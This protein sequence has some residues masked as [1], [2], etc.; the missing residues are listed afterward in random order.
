M[1]VDCILT[2]T[3]ENTL[4]SDFIPMFIRMWRTLVPTADIKIIY[5]ADEIP[6]K[7]KNYEDNLILFKPIDGINTAFIAQYIRILYPSL[8]NYEGG[9]IITDMDMMPMNS[10][11]YV[12]NIK[13]F[14]NDKFIYYRDWY[15]P[16]QIAICYNIATPKVWKEINGVNSIED[17]IEKL[18]TANNQITYAGTHGG[19]GWSKDQIDLRKMVWSWKG[20]STRF[21]GLRDMY[22]GYR[23]L[24]RAH[25]YINQQ[26]EDMIR[27]LQFTDFHAHRP[28]N[29]NKHLNDYIADLVCNGREDI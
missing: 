14:S 16:D 10:N 3:N 2:A 15:S 12:D 11:Y 6:F 8:F 29:Q 21:I 28:Y 4:Y 23:R 27:D 25:F 17:V 13:D 5:I 24:D 19:S 22:S 20:F 18:K 1:K 7:F 9:V 26:I